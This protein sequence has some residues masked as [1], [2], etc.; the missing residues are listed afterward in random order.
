MENDVLKQ[1]VNKE[2]GYLE[3]RI[4]EGLWI[5]SH[6]CAAR[7]V[8]YVAESE[9]LFTAYRFYVY[10]PDWKLCDDDIRLDK[11]GSIA[12]DLQEILRNADNNRKRRESFHNEKHRYCITDF[13]DNVMCW[14]FIRC[15]ADDV[16][17]EDRPHN[18]SGCK[19]EPSV[20]WIPK[21][22]SSRISAG[23][24]PDAVLDDME[25]VWS[26]LP[27]VKLMVK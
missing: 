20:I 26:E 27:E 14:S 16:T 13:R 25:H 17:L 10:R 19:G 23:E 21:G 15:K 1:I 22:S 18:G 8:A 2:H 6:R 3:E 7:T 4:R 24:I 12:G 9:G 5:R 11:D